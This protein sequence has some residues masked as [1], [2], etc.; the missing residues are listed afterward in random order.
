MKVPQFK[1][2]PIRSDAPP[3]SAWGV[4][5]QG[6]RRDVLGT[7]NFITPE[8]V[9]ATR[10]EI[11]TGESTVLNLPLHLPYHSD[12]IGR[13]KTCHKLLADVFDMTACDDEVTVNTQSMSQWDGLSINPTSILFQRLSY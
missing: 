1:D 10:E 7:L 5:D 11:R 4:F 6:A 13:I 9:V 8:V 12:R 3:G 2:L